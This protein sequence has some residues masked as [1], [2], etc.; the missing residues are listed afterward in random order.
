MSNNPNAK[1]LH[2]VE[3]LTEDIL[4]LAGGKGSSLGTGGMAT[5]LH[6][7]GIATAAGIDM[8][9]T[10]GASPENL[11]RI[12]DGESVGTR[13]KAGGNAK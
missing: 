11:Y 5:K 8:V 4:K 9:I 6:A 7:A 12:V 3:A 10:N 13:F 1:L 2:T